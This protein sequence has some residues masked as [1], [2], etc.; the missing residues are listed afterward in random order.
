VGDFA[1][2]RGQLNR[3]HPITVRAPEETDIFHVPDAGDAPGFANGTP[4]WRLQQKAAASLVEG[5][6]HLRA[7]RSSL[8]AM[9]AASSSSFSFWNVSRAPSLS[10]HTDSRASSRALMRVRRAAMI[11]VSTGIL[12]RRIVAPTLEVF[13]RD[14]VN[15][16]VECEVSGNAALTQG[17]RTPYLKSGIIRTIP[18]EHRR[19]LE[20][21]RQ[22]CR[23][24]Q[25]TM[26]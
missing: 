23:R 4:G 6:G 13:A 21:S 22:A 2:W 14:V 12:R 1:C 26:R 18:G 7:T 3:K 9:R 8:T 17:L 20:E 10:R 19:C 15:E 24:C 25:K 16:V 11:S 5:L